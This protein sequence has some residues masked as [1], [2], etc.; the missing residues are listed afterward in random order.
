M[1]IGPGCT[2]VRKPYG[3][4]LR[5][6]GMPFSSISSTRSGML[7]STSRTFGPPKAKKNMS[8]AP[9]VRH[10]PRLAIAFGET[11][12]GEHG[13][14]QEINGAHRR[15]AELDPLA[16]HVGDRLQ[17]AVLAHEK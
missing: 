10:S 11:R 8:L 15:V 16:L 3:V 9:E 5:A 4:T 7:A 14:R 1:K 12:R 6:A 17:R 13:A 2:D